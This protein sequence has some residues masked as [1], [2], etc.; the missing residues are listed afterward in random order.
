MFCRRRSRRELTFVRKESRVCINATGRTGRYFF[1]TV[2]FVYL[3]TWL[4]RWRLSRFQISQ[5][6]PTMDEIRTLAMNSLKQ[7]R[8]D[9]K[10]VL[11]P[12]PYKVGQ[13]CPFIHQMCPF[14]TKTCPLFV[15]FCRCLCRTTSTNSC[16]IFGWRTLLLGSCLKLIWSCPNKSIN[17]L[18]CD[19][20]ASSA[21]DVDCWVLNV[22]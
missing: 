15:F 11:N 1:K 22:R 3:L 9:H 2:L 14:S 16:T 21:A 19:I 5:S 8:T 17:L 6:L 12:T 10:R 7:L 13:H 18:W 20:P 4:S